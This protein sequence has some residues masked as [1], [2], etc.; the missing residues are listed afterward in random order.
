MAPYWFVTN[1]WNIFK[2]S[3]ESIHHRVS[4]LLCL[5]HL[6]SPPISQRGS[7]RVKMMQPYSKRGANRRRRCCSGTSILH[8]VPSIWGLLNRKSPLF[9]LEDSPKYL[10]I[11][12]EQQFLSFKVH[13]LGSLDPVWYW[14]PV[15]RSENV[16]LSLTST[17]LIKFSCVTES[18]LSHP[19]GTCPWPQLLIRER[20]PTRSRQ[21]LA[22]FGLSLIQQRKPVSPGDNCWF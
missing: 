15:W 13:D 19:D 16:F 1:S 9:G 11:Q 2:S 12:K 3:Y 4:V 8:P 17:A 14:R 21:P 10:L 20:I 22:I 7:T 5:F 18:Y 6:L